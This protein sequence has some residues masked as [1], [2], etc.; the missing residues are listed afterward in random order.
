MSVKQSN[1]D[2]HLFLPILKK[3]ATTKYKLFF[4]HPDKGKGI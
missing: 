3:T 2:Q 1:V 4:P